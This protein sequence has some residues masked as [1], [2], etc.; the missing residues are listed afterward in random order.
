[1]D[2]SDDAGEFRLALGRRIGDV[3]GK[4]PTKTA[5]ADA[6]GITLEQL[7]KWIA[8][9]VK[10]PVEGLWR[11]S[12]ESNTDFSLL[13]TGA[14]NIYTIRSPRARPFQEEVLRD[15]LGA[16]AK[17]IGEEGVTFDPKRFA[18]L[19]FAMHDYV[20]ERRTKDGVDADLDGITRFI[21]LATRS[22]R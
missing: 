13:C 9:T 11:L 5:A 20:I 10:V 6:A 14:N 15:V 1:M 17:V 22:Q 16:F 4:F 18:D 2:I 8:G 3:V 19:A 21:S 12:R 7:N